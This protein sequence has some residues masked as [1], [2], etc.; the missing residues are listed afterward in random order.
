MFFISLKIAANEIRNIKSITIYLS[1]ILD[2]SVSSIYYCSI[3]VTNELSV[4]VLPP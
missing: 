2:L 1:P 3:P 4:V